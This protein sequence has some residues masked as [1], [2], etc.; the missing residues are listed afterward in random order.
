MSATE[1]H[2]RRRREQASEG[3]LQNVNIALVLAMFLLIREVQKV[4]HVENPLVLCVKVVSGTTGVLQHV[5]ISLVL[6][7]FLL[8]REVQKVKNDENPLVLCVRSGFRHHRSSPTCQDFI[9]CS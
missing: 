5:N 4:K 7:M 2:G 3:A 9:G 8:I 1:A 6:A